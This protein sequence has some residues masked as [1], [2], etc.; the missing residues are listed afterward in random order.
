MFL[1]K[2]PELNRKRLVVSVLMLVFRSLVFPWAVPLFG[3]GAER[4]P[5]GP[6]LYSV[7]GR[8]GG[9]ARAEFRCF[10]DGVYGRNVC[11]IYL[12]DEFRMPADWRMKKQ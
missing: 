4:R 6:R 11:I 5:A 7:L 3:A 9:E 1:S 10:A 12:S 8:K 2:S